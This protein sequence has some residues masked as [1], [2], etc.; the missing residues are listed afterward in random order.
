MYPITEAGCVRRGTH[1]AKGRTNWLAP[2]NAALRHLHYGRIVL[3]EG[4]SPAQFST[5][6][7]ETGLVCLSGS[8]SVLAA[9]A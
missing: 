1:L 9:R 3:E 8:G 4:G 7:Q 2:G 6:I 5:G